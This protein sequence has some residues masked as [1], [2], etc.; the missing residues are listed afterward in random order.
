MAP[1]SQCVS[2]DLPPVQGSLIPKPTFFVLSSCS[3]HSTMDET[4]GHL[5]EMISGFSNELWQVG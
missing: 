4:L 5:C 3:N 1:S 2:Y